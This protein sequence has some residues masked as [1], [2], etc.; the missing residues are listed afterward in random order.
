MNKIAQIYKAINK[1]LER[2]RLA[3]NRQFQSEN[4][5]YNN[6]KITLKF[7]NTYNEGNNKPKNHMNNQL[8]SNFRSEENM[9]SNSINQSQDNTLNNNEYSIDNKRNN[10][11]DSSFITY[12]PQSQTEIPNLAYEYLNNISG[13]DLMS[14]ENNSVISNETD[15]EE[16]KK[17][18]REKIIAETLSKNSSQKRFVLNKKLLS[19]YQ[20][21][22]SK[23]HTALGHYNSK[24]QGTLLY[25]QF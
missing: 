15:Q 13:Y 9:I 4:P 8:D 10:L 18:Q 20:N 11:I 7:Q 6:S 24:L 25:F 12:N 19:Q 2:S 5:H 22:M 14:D 1:N 17:I 3:N 21:K 23:V 16:G